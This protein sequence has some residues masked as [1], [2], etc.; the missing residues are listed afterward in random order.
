MDSDIPFKQNYIYCLV[1]AT[2]LL[3]EVVMTLNYYICLPC[4]R[5]REGYGMFNNIGGN[6]DD[7]G[8]WTFNN[9]SYGSNAK[10]TV[11]K[12]YSDMASY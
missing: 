4:R 10:H 6:N 3:L 11:S 5:R 7:D 1:C 8:E 2:Y 12:G 9:P